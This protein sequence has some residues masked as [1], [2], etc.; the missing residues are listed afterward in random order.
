MTLAS[1]AAALLLLLT[2][3]PTNVL[4]ATGAALSGRRAGLM[5]VPAVLAAYLTG[6]AALSLG[7]GPLL[8]EHPALQTSLKVACAGIVALIAVRLW[9]AAAPDRQADAVTMRRVFTVTA[10]NPKVFVMAFAFVPAGATS[11]DLLRLL[12]VLVV[13][14]TLSSVA[15]VVFGSVLGAAGR[16]RTLARSGAVALGLCAALLSGSVLG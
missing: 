14:V 11:S 12:P 15:W 5:L 8:Q 7:L 3:G 16:R 6:V 1:F 4:L 9:R 13:L 10:V 2:P